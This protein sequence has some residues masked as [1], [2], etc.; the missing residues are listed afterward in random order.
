[1]SKD[2]K[3]RK[4]VN[5]KLKGVAEKLYADASSTSDV[6]IKP[7]DFPG[8]IPKLSVKV[9]DKVK[10]GSPLFYNKEIDR[11][12]FTSPI[13]GEVT[14]INRGEKRRILEV[15]VRADGSNT[16]ETFKQGDPDNMAKEEILDTML[17]SGVWPFIRQR[18]YD[19]IANPMDTPK[20]I[21][22]TAFDS[23]PLAPDFGFIA[24]GQGDLLQV[25]LDALTKLTSGTVHLNITGNA[26]ADEAFNSAKSVQINKISGPHPAGNVGIQMHHIDPINKGEVVWVLNALDVLTIGKV[27]KEGKFDASR[28]IA[29]AGSKITTPKYVK[30]I[31][32]A[33]VGDFLKGNLEE[34]ARVISGNPLTG[35]HIQ[36]DGHLG[37]YNYQ[38]T[39]IPA[40]GEPRFMGWLPF[41]G[42]TGFSL[43]RTSF[44][45]LNPNKE[46][47]LD[48]NI[49]GEERAF[50]MA[51]Q[52]EKLFP[53]DIFPVHLVK[54]M[55]Y[56]DIDLMENLGVY[57]VAPEDFAL[58]EYACTSKIETQKIV[59][60]ALDLVRKE[61]S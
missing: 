7:T 49:N 39:A 23:A 1:M 34:E 60:E 4:G 33:N 6:V 48:A 2:V 8:L 27:F 15:K 25:G 59:R 28:T 61:T 14:E 46:R 37:F 50:V 21:H 45:F 13:S 29:V 41:L 44:S 52:Y 36:S 30:T 57:E 42:F 53:M 40:G 43:S 26:N 5:I 31:L 35:T 9:G 47:D 17:K 12:L 18:P 58:C 32:G 22:V 38:I 3:I 51:G 16:Y 54:S 20:A 24:H 11:V 19:V 10:A 56:K 55:I